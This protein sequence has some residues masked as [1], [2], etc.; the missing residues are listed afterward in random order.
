MEKEYWK[1]FKLA[2]GYLVKATGLIEITMK[3]KMKSLGLSSEEISCFNVSYC[4]GFE[5]EI[6]YKGESLLAHFSMEDL[7]EMETSEELW[8]LVNSFS[9]I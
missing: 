8:E 9:K 2:T 1:M 4:N 5:T 6:T 7:L 3:E